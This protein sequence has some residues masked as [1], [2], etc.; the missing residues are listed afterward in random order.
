MNEGKAAYAEANGEEEPVTEAEM[1]EVKE[2]AAAE[3]EA[4][5]EEETT[6]EA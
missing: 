2:E 1:A 4:A 3:A 6:E 5:T